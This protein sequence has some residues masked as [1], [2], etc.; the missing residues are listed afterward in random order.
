MEISVTQKFSDGSDFSTVLFRIF[1]NDFA[2]A[3]GNIHDIEM[4]EYPETRE[5]EII[6]WM[7]HSLRIS[8]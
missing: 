5:G 7:T 8:I 2:K 4:G 6:F 3:I 1:M